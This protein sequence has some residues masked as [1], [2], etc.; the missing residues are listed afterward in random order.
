MDNLFALAAPATVPTPAAQVPR[1]VP[2]GPVT[3]EEKNE[4]AGPSDADDL[5]EQLANLTP[6]AA[7]SD[8]GR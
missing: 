4:T 3:D 1:A 5:S 6:Q 7:G 8:E 2:A